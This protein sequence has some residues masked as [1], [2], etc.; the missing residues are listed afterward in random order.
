MHQNDSPSLSL[1]TKWHEGSQGDNKKRK[2]KTSN[3]RIIKTEKRHYETLICVKG[4]SGWA[5]LYPLKKTLP[6]FKL[7]ESSKSFSKTRSKGI[8]GIF[9]WDSV[10]R[11]SFWSSKFTNRQTDSFPLSFL[12]SPRQACQEKNKEEQLN[13]KKCQTK[14]TGNPVQNLRKMEDEAITTFNPKGLATFDLNTWAWQTE[15]WRKHQLKVKISVIFKMQNSRTKITQV[16]NGSIDRNAS[17]FE[18]K[19]LFYPRTPSVGN[20][21]EIAQTQLGFFL[22]PF[23]F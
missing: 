1:V 19:K 23:L 2:Q 22:L 7:W 14:F 8:W 5:T 6:F 12:A 3:M 21:R 15:K 18:I 10:P 4:Y 9:S 16:E 11:T 20:E 13:M 17:K